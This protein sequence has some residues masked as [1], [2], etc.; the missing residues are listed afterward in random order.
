VDQSGDI[1]EITLNESGEIVGEELVGTI[2][3][4]PVEEEYINE[5]GWNVTRVRAESGNTFEYLSNDA[6]N[7][8]GV[9]AV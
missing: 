6:G 1:I 4:L 2:S 3:S 7:I 5:E 9:R 8:V